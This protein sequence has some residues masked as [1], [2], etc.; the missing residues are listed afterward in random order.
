MKI[1][2]GLLF[3]GKSVEHEVSVITAIQA[4][5][6]FDKGK[7]DIVPIY[8]SRQGDFYCGPDIGKIEAYRDIKA[9]MARSVRVL[10]MGENGRMKLLRQPPKKF[11]DNV[12]A[13]IDVAFPAVHGTNVEDGALQGYLQTIGVP[14]VG[15]DVLSSALGMDKYAMK[16]VLKDNG[17]PVLPCVRFDVKRWS[18]KREELIEE[19][20]DALRYPIII[21]PVNLGSSVGIKIA[22]DRD[23]LAEAVDYAFNYASVVIAENA[24][25]NLREINCSVLGDYET[26]EAS[27][28]EEP[29]NT[30]EI[31]SYDDKY[32]GGDGK[33]GG[34]KGMSG[35]KRLLPAPIS[36]ELR[37]Q[38]R[39]LAI[40]TFKALGC[41]GVSRIDFLLDTQENKLWVNEINTIPGSLSFYLWEPLGV[42]YTELLD[43]M[44]SLA[45]K[46]EREAAD[47]SYSFDTNILANFG[48]GI[49]GGKV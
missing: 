33:K 31:L 32:G 11:G 37:E 34:G 6:S 35:L 5:N 22:H 36:P 45:L 19:L 15:C 40:K 1:K 8:I 39:S 7:Y 25:V 44:V 13:V 48:G 24:I 21:K 28:C 14:Y 47:I 2:V 38:V 4:M 46:R 17:L 16:A 9:L 26:A 42:K 29:I 49:K 3:G 18:R 20:E 41:N 23:G 30:D 12:Y 10:P 27:E 43:R